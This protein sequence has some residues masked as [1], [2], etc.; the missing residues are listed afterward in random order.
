MTSAAVLSVGA[1]AT[2]GDP[3]T[4][5]TITGQITSIL[6]TALTWVG[7]VITTVT[8]TPLIMFFVLLGG[9]YIGVNMLRKLLHI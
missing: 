9:I 6:T 8:G 7:Q 5:T 3:V 4:V 2:D 1:F